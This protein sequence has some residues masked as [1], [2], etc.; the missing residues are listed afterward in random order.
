[1]AHF[2]RW[3]PHIHLRF[4]KRSFGQR[5]LKNPLFANIWVFKHIT[6][7]SFKLLM[8]HLNR[9]HFNPCTRCPPLVVGRA[10]FVVLAGAED[11]SGDVLDAAWTFCSAETLLIYQLFRTQ[12]R[13]FGGLLLCLESRIYV[14]R[15][16]FA[17]LVEVLLV[18][19][20]NHHL[21]ERRERIFTFFRKFAI[22]FH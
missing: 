4:E 16:T 22:S 1:M 19:W 13:V 5:R 6:L 20:G 18:I 11:G 15:R 2:A 3:V 17:H 12:R 9:R 10:W 14:F 7:Q 21:A 8:T